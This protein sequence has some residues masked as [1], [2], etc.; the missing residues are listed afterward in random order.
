[1]RP[2]AEQRGPVTLY[3]SHG[4]GSGRKDPDGPKVDWF[5]VEPRDDPGRAVA[6]LRRAGRTVI[7]LDTEPYVSDWHFFHRARP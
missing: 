6:S 3:I 7:E 1:M 5:I 2:T 4:A